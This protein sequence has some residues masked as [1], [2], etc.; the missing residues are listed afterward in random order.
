MIE[1]S[2]T[3]GIQPVSVTYRVYVGPS[4]QFEGLLF[5]MVGRACGMWL[6]GSGCVQLMTAPIPVNQA[7]GSEPS[8]L[9]LPG[10]TLVP[11]SPS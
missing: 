11:I 6:C 9:Y 7:K 8:V 10:P 3:I 2:M 4:S 1:V 5:I